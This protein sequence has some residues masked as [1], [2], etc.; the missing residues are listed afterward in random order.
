MV[1]NKLDKNWRVVNLLKLFCVLII[2]GIIVYS[3]PI[4]WESLGFGTDTPIFNISPKIWMF[5]FSLVALIVVLYIIWIFLFYKSFWYSLDKEGIRIH[6]GIITISDMLI[7]YN[8]IRNVNVTRG[9]FQRFFNIGSIT[10]ELIGYTEADIVESD[11]PGIKNAEEIAK[12]LLK[13]I[14]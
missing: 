9:L 2:L 4:V 13:K 11:I 5:V 14:A 6:K 10:I 1:K 3:F 12:K 7:P 8:K